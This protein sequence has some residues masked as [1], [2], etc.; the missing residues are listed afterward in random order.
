MWR[1]PAQWCGVPRYFSVLGGF[2]DGG[3]AATELMRFC[4]NTCS[5]TYRTYK[6]GPPFC[7]PSFVRFQLP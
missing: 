3:I 6:R 5:T 4:S 1:V 2:D 7:L